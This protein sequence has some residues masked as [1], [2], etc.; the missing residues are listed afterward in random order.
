MSRIE[1]VKDQLKALVS[2]LGNIIQES[3]SYAKLK[4]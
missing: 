1:E 3:E 2:R 4:D